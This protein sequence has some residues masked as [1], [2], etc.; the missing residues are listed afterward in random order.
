VKAATIGIRTLADYSVWLKD[1][2]H[3]SHLVSCPHAH[4]QNGAAE[5]KHRHIVKVGLSLLA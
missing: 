3:I 2:Q 4:Q 1:R 5:R